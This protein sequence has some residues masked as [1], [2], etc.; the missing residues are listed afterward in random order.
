MGP[1]Y[2]SAPMLPFF[3]FFSY[4]IFARIR[5]RNVQIL[6]K[7]SK[8]FS[9]VYVSKETSKK[10]LTKRSITGSRAFEEGYATVDEGKFQ[11]S[12]ETLA[13]AHRWDWLFACVDSTPSAFPCLINIWSVLERMFS[14][15]YTHWQ[16]PT[17]LRCGYKTCRRPQRPLQA[18]WLSTGSMVT[19][20]S[21]SKALSFVYNHSLWNTMIRLLTILC[22]KKVMSALHLMRRHH[23]CE[24]LTVC[25]SPKGTNPF[26]TSVCWEVNKAAVAMYLLLC[27]ICTI[28]RKILCVCVLWN[29]FDPCEALCLFCIIMLKKQYDWMQH[30]TMQHSK[31]HSPSDQ[32]D[33]NCHFSH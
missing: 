20:S 26:Y 10:Y 32:T 7:K 15:D 3:F 24:C 30:S 12:Y 11:T 22:S 6:R 23:F 16:T 5:Q 13:C 25:V 17:G 14:C 8:F 2:D 1:S 27:A 29:V 19:S 28:Y 31:H 21:A 18:R 4:F 9:Y 33:H